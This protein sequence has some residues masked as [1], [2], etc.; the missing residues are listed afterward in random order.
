[1]KKSGLFWL[2]I[3]SVIHYIVYTL[4][5]RYFV[6]TY[7]SWYIIAVIIHHKIKHIDDFIYEKYGDLTIDTSAFLQLFK[8]YPY[9]F[10][11]LHLLV[12]GICVLLSNL[13]ANFLIFLYD[14]IILN[15]IKFIYNL[16]KNI[17]DFKIEDIKINIPKKKKSFKQFIKGLGK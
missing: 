13:I 7:I 2:I 14:K 17:D 11:T 16:N 3:I 8:E 6:G 5:I 10:T 4:G 1:M 15:V 12:F 9:L